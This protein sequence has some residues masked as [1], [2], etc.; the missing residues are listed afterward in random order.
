[1]DE[2][3]GL[4]K[5]NVWCYKSELS[6]RW[7]NVKLEMCLIKLLIIVRGEKLRFDRRWKEG[8]L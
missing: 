3:V 6:Y 7:I 1:M 2:K 4:G 8:K 5:I